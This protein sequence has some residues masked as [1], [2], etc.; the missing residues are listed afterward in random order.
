MPRRRKTLSSPAAAS[1]NRSSS[2]SPCSRWRSQTRSASAGARARSA[3][4]TRATCGSAA[5][6]SAVYSSTT[7]AACRGEGLVSHSE[8]TSSGCTGGAELPRL[9]AVL[10][11]A[12]AAARST[13]SARESPASAASLASS[14]SRL[15]R[16]FSGISNLR[17]GAGDCGPCGVQQSSQSAPPAVVSC[18]AGASSPGAVLLRSALSITSLIR[19]TAM[20]APVLSD[21]ILPDLTAGVVRMISDA[22]ESP[23]AEWPSSALDVRRIS[24]SVRRSVWALPSASWPSSSNELHTRCSPSNAPAVSPTSRVI[25]SPAAIPLGALYLAADAS[26]AI[27]AAAASSAQ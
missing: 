2:S 13:R 26:L 22:S 14:S 27:S 20:E 17:R 16:S 12:A 19:S 7:T 10:A 4:R 1:T 21:E 3:A 15:K 11:R 8:I 9:A 23:R 24:S 25:T 5:A 6:R 18:P